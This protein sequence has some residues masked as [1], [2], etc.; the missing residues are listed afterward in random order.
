MAR[1]SDSGRHSTPLP[2]FGGSLGLFLT[3]RS[4]RSCDGLQ[5]APLLLV[6]SR[7][8]DVAA[9]EAVPSAAAA[10]V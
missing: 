8:V 9:I 7:G 10:V 3:E 1:S 6:A 2:P 5:I 4:N